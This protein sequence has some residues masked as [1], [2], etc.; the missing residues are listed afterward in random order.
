MNWTKAIWIANM[1]LLAFLGYLVAGI[2]LRKPPELP[3]PPQPAMHTQR[4][5]QTVAPV[6]TD[7]C[8]T[9]LGRNIFGVSDPGDNGPAG[10]RAPSP[11]LAKTQL[12]L[13]L[14]GTVAGD[15]SIARAII[16]ELPNK[17]Q[18]LY[19]TGD[20]VQGATIERIERNRVILLHDQRREI[21]ELYVTATGA[22][23]TEL[24]ETATLPDAREA[25]SVISPT[26]FRID[27]RALLA[28]IGGVEAILKVAKLQPYVVDGQ[29]EG[30]RITGIENVA[31]ARF[32]GIEDGDVV[33]TVNGQHLTSQ[34]K[35]FQV[36]RK[37]RT[38][39]SLDVRL[40]RGE[41]EKRLTF[42]LK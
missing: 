13:R 27:K 2:V 41:E 18:D 4:S 1:A 7:D 16:E 24:A 15:E 22:S 6:T 29:T 5:A 19:K 42:S 8:S 37:A 21:L 10:S 17:A 11:P 12:Q 3:A 33:R 25:V 40:L 26:E 30:L 20:I 34:Q 28:R 14:L 35:A 23:E 39:P 36:F 9:I 32:V 38:Q 31:M